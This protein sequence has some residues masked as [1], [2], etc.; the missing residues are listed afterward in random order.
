MRGLRAYRR[1]TGALRTS[2]S[3]HRTPAAILWRR[4]RRVE[5]RWHPTLAVVSQRRWP[6]ASTRITSTT[7]VAA[8]IVAARLPDAIATARIKCTTVVAAVAVAARRTAAVASRAARR[9]AAAAARERRAGSEVRIVVVHATILWVRSAPHWQAAMIAVPGP[10][11]IIVGAPHWLAASPPRGP[12]REA[13]IIAVHAAV[14]TIVVAQRVAAWLARV[15]AVHEAS[16][17]CAP[18]WRP[19][20][21]ARKGGTTIMAIR[22]TVGTIT[23]AGSRPLVECAATPIW[24][25]ARVAALEAVRAATVIATGPRPGEAAVHS[26]AVA[27][28]VSAVVIWALSVGSRHCRTSFRWPCPLLLLLSGTEEV[29]CI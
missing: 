12:S 16:I 7:V 3:L 27:V 2:P 25:T 28:P 23:I 4:A 6:A 8:V 17:A 21:A 5:V 18:H 9:W 22:P 14:V 15:H 26:R 20:A 10:V 11:V 1:R 19:G 24:S 13:G 29:G